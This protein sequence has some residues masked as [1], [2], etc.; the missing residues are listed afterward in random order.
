MFVSNDI[1]NSGS[2]CSWG[3]ISG[4]NLSGQTVTQLNGSTI[5][6]F[7]SSGLNVGLSQT[8]YVGAINTSKAWGI[9]KMTDGVPNLCRGW[10]LLSTQVYNNVGSATV[11]G[12]G[13]CFCAPVKYPFIV[14][15]NV[16]GNTT[17][18]LM[19]AAPL[20]NTYITGH[21]TAGTAL[22]GGSPALTTS[23]HEVELYV[24]GRCSLNSTIIAYSE[25][26]TYSEIFYNFKVSKGPTTLYSDLTK[27]TF[28]AIVHF[29]ILGI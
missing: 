1:C 23:P 9:I 8:G 16:Y 21:A 13:I 6:C 7:N 2:I 11:F 26:N 17:N 18:P 10:N 14:N 12:M 19:C 27:S 25:N 29:N 22:I 28:D 3:G 20:A 24:S 4:L 15:F 5:T